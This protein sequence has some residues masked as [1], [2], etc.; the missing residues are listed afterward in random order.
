MLLSMDQLGDVRTD[1]L[2]LEKDL[3]I[4]FYVT[5]PATMVKI[6]ENYQELDDLLGDLFDQVHFNVK[7]SETRV[8]NFNRPDIQTAGSQKVDVRI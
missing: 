1:F 8:K 7:V 6:Q 5:E 4:N 3:N 2:L